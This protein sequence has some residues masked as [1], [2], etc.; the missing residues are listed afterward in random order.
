M[1]SVCVSHS[2]LTSLFVQ[3][4]PNSVAFSSNFTPLSFAQVLWHFE[5]CNRLC[6]LPGPDRAQGP[7]ERCGFLVHCEHHREP[8]QHFVSDYIWH[9]VSSAPC[10]WGSMLTPN[11]LDIDYRWTSI[12]QYSKAIPIYTHVIKQTYFIRM[13]G[14]GKA[15]L[16]IYKVNCM[17]HWLTSRSWSPIMLP[18]L[19]RPPWEGQCLWMCLW[20]IL[21]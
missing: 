11:T 21:L 18:L 3:M 6:Q 1:W 4:I 15:S 5:T 13:Q 2:T 16:E 14:W 12:H 9:A 10:G 8:W 7:D 19:V 20:L 17:P